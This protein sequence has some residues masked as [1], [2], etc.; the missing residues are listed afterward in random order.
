ME[1]TTTPLEEVR[2][3]VQCHPL[4]VQVGRGARVGSIIAFVTVAILVAAWLITR[5]AGISFTDLSRDPAATLDGPWYTGII[6]TTSIVVLVVGAGIALFSA[7]LLRE[8]PRGLLAGLGCLVLLIA[9]DDQFMLHEEVF[10][11]VGIGSIATGAFYAAALSTVVAIWWRVIVEHTDWVFLLLAAGGLGLSVAIDVI[12]EERFIALPIPGELV[13][14]PAKILGMAFMTYF[15]V[16]TARRPLVELI[17]DH[18]DR[19]RT[20]GRAR[21][22]S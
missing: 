8:S 22:P 15:L 4:G 19:S 16:S 11:L 14:D 18:P 1:Y 5:Y 17:D 12:L 2:T 21:R 7:S 10:P 3:V 20:I 9:I 13:E 6:S